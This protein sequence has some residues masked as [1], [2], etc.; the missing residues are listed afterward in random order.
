MA[1][2]EDQRQLGNARKIAPQQVE[3]LRG[4]LTY[5]RHLTSESLKHEFQ[6]NWGIELG[7]IGIFRKLQSKYLMI[8]YS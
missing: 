8:T 2:L 6:S 5:N 4:I 3:L 7:V 1:G